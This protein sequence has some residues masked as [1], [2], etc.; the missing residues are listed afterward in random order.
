MG[1][2]QQEGNFSK[3]KTVISTQISISCL[4]RRGYF[5]IRLRVA[6]PLCQTVEQLQMKEYNFTLGEK[7]WQMKQERLNIHTDQ[8]HKML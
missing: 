6:G 3:L 4:L 2:K 1:T 5:H 8:S 7:E